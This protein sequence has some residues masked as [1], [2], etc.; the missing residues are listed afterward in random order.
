MR[1]F[2]DD[3][4]RM[5]WPT[6]GL[7]QRWYKMLEMALTFALE[8]QTRLTQ[9]KER[10]AHLEQLALTDELTGLLNRRGFE[11][12]FHQEMVGAKRHGEGGV[13]IFIDLDGFKPVNDTFGHEAGDEVLRQVAGL[14]R[15]H[16]RESDSLARIGGDE[17]V[18]LMPRSPRQIGLA[19]AN[20]LDFA[21][22]NAYAVWQ[23]AMITL[24]ASC[25]VQAYLPSDDWRQ[26]LHTADAEMYRKKRETT[27]MNANEA[28]L[29][30]RNGVNA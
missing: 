21:I 28:V 14:L 10:L 5:G 7:F 22:N 24:R 27:E 2:I 15:G 30:A 25:G 4:E 13:V 1:R 11:E 19:R 3:V 18:V 8:S 20:D 12:R 26:T 16:V 9:T 6:D 29:L 17:F 23:G